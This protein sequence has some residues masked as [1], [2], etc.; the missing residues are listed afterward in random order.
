MK[1]SIQTFEHSPVAH[2]I[3]SETIDYDNA[4][5]AF[6]VFGS[7]DP[8][9]VTVMIGPLTMTLSREAMREAFEKVQT[10]IETVPPVERPTF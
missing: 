4:S 6:T 5:F 10:A 8:N 3:E 1:R 7:E 9:I 2:I